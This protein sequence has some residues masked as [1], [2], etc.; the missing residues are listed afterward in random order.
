MRTYATSLAAIIFL[1][2]SPAHADPAS[3]QER[4]TRAGLSTTGLIAGQNA[5]LDG[6]DIAI[7]SGDTAESV[8]ARF[9]RQHATVAALRTENTRL[10]TENTRLAGR[11]RQLEAIF[12]AP[13]NQF[14]ETFW[15]AWAAVL[16]H[17]TF[18][19]GVLLTA[20]VFMMNGRRIF[21]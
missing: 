16:G 5:R 14:K 21:R 19:A 4:F 8:C 13:A 15:I 20:L 10:T 11:N 2:A 3:C 18:D 9:D 6:E 1:M 12:N 17:L 7:V